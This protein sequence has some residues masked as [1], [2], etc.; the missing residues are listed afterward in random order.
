MGGFGTASATMVVP[1]CATFTSDYFSDHDSFFNNN[2]LQSTVPSCSTI[3]TTTPSRCLAHQM[4]KSLG[5]SSELYLHPNTFPPILPQ[6]ASSLFTTGLSHSVT[7]PPPPPPECLT[8]K[9]FRLDE[10]QFWCLDNSSKNDNSTSVSSSAENNGV[11]SWG[12][13]KEASSSVSHIIDSHDQMEGVKWTATDYI[14]N[15]CLSMAAAAAAASLQNQTQQSSYSEIKSEG[16]HF[17][18]SSGSSS[19]PWP[20]ESHIS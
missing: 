18:T 17:I 12:A 9:P 14:Q 8:M 4:G 20:Q 6:S 19:L 5:T 10:N 7:P 1:N 2:P 11:F 16:Y 13:V 3:W 15:S